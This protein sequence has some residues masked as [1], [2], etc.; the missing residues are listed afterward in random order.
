MI[1]GHLLYILSFFNFH[2]TFSVH[3]SCNAQ[4]NELSRMSM[5]ELPMTGISANV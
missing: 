3:L 2:Q 1:A 4:N 5:R